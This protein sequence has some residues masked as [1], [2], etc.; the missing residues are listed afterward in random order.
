MMIEWDV[1]QRYLRI[2]QPRFL[3]DLLW[4]FNMQEYKPIS[5][6]IECRIR[7]LEGECA[8]GWKSLSRDDSLPYVRD[9]YV[10]P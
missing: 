5:T 2:G 7:L 1:E 3:E 6:P 9:L 8:I 4:Q 10:A